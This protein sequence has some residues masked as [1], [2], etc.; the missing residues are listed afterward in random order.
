MG[1]YQL[2]LT[3]VG[4]KVFDVNVVSG[5][6]SVAGSLHSF[7]VWFEVTVILGDAGALC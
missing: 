4:K 5:I 2:S 7:T 6:M 1:S 3:Q